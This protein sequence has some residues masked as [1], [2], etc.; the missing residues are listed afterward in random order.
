MNAREAMDAFDR[1]NERDCAARLA[2]AEAQRFGE[3]PVIL[4]EKPKNPWDLPT[5]SGDAIQQWRESFTCLRVTGKNVW[6]DDAPRKA[7]VDVSGGGFGVDVT[8][9]GGFGADAVRGGGFGVDAVRGGGFGNVDVPR[10]GDATRGGGFGV[11]VTRGGGFG[12]DITRGGGFGNVDGAA[13]AP[14]PR[15][16]P[17]PEIPRVP[18]DRMGPPG[19]R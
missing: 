4:P 18:L 6:A 13:P 19:R 5:G 10:G 11:D 12:A 3:V 15:R 7:A 2:H 16:R 8:R 14:P 17:L 1:E 9:G